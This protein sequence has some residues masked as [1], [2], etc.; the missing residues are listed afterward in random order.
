MITKNKSDK[1][2]GLPFPSSPR[3]EMTA[4]LRHAKAAWREIYEQ[5]KWDAITTQWENEQA[6]FESSMNYWTQSLA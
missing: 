2:W 6:D 3:E 4:K 1:N 5:E